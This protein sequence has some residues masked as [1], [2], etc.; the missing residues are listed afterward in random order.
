[1]PHSLTHKTLLTCD[2]VWCKIASRLITH[3]DV[4]TLWINC[5][6][7]RFDISIPTRFIYIRSE[8][9]ILADV[10]IM[11]QLVQSCTV[12]PTINYVQTGTHDAMTDSVAY[13][14]KHIHVKFGQWGTHV[15]SIRWDLGLKVVSTIAGKQCAISWRPLFI[16]SKK[17]TFKSLIIFSNMKMQRCW[18]IFSCFTVTEM[19]RGTQIHQV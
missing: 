2:S 5:P 8:T 10:C 19:P 7:C 1:M 11:I 3:I 4:C 6:L 17:V 16:S 14:Y 12:Y 18:C 15:L 13:P 9:H